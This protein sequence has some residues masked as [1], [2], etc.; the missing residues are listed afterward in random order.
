MAEDATVASPSNL[1]LWAIGGAAIH[2][3]SIGNAQKIVINV[4]HFR[5][6]LHDFDLCVSR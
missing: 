6:F 4:D 3:V 1:S 2:S 5:V